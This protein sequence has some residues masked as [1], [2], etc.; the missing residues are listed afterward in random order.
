[1]A[2]A[3][4]YNLWVKH[5]LYTYVHSSHHSEKWMTL[6]NICAAASVQKLEGQPQKSMKCLNLQLEKKL[7]AAL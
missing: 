4:L 1:M 6:Q 2:A 3:A 5:F 7:L